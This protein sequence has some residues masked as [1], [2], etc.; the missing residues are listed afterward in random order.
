MDVRQRK[1]GQKVRDKET[2]WRHEY[3]Q[4]GMHKKLKAPLIL[5][6]LLLS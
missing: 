2:V 5:Y 1:R 6:V 3:V 4:F